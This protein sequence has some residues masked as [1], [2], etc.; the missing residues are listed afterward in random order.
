MSLKDA[1]QT[2]V[3]DVP[4]NETSLFQIIQ[5]YFTDFVKVVKQNGTYEVFEKNLFFLKAFGL[6]ALI[7]LAVVNYALTKNTGLISS[8][9]LTFFKESV[10]FA[11][12]GVVPFLIVAYLR[13]NFYSMREIIMMAIVIFIV[14]FILNYL[15]EL[16]GFYAWSF[17]PKVDKATDPDIDFPKTVARTSEYMLVGIVAGSFIAMIFASLFVFNISPMYV[18]TNISPTIVFLMEMIL[19]GVISAVPVYIIASNR[20]DLSTKTNVEFLA[21][22]LKFAIL[23]CLLQISGFYNHAFNPQK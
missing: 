10:L 9:P 5:G 19:F 2:I 21:L 6:I 15:L 14:M 16:S 8:K 20:N 22:F 13:N 23:H 4:T 12:G 18:H 11:I 17:D 1:F 7:M 3:T